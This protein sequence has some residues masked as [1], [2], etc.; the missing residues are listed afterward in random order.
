MRVFDD[1]RLRC[2]GLAPDAKMLL[3]RLEQDRIPKARCRFAGDKKRLSFAVMAPTSPPGRVAVQFRS[4]VL[5]RTGSGERC[6]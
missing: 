4:L 1:V 3:A 6:G 5:K 2:S